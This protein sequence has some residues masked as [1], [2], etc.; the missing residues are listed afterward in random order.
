MQRCHVWMRRHKTKTGSVGCESPYHF[1]CSWR[2]SRS[3]HGTCGSETGYRSDCSRGH[4]WSRRGDSKGATTNNNNNSSK[5]LGFPWGYNTPTV[6]N[7]TILCKKNKQTQT[8]WRSTGP[9]T[10]KAVEVRPVSILFLVSAKGWSIAKIG[11]GAYTKLPWRLL[12]AEAGYSKGLWA[13]LQRS[14][15]L[16]PFEAFALL[17][18]TITSVYIEGYFQPQQLTAQVGHTFSKFVYFQGK[19]KS[20]TSHW[21]QPSTEITITCC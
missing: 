9:V 21:C 13:W 20:I 19:G 4:K 16:S 6:N 10:G 7:E 1:L 12:I 15:L 17:Y 8:C 11:K 2:L 18:K 3:C 14:W 5:W